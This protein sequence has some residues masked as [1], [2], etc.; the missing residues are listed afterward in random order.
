MLDAVPD[1]FGYEVLTPE[2][3]D[4]E[5]HAKHLSLISAADGTYDPNLHMPLYLLVTKRREWREDVDGDRIRRRGVE[6]KEERERERK[7][8]IQSAK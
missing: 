2:T 7:E 4:P 5:L 3:A 6:E 8:R 1:A